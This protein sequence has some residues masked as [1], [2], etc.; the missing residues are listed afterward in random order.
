MIRLH[1]IDRASRAAYADALDQH[2]ALRLGI[3]E[4][5]CRRVLRAG[6]GGTACDPFDT[7]ATRYLLA[8]DGAGRVAGGTRLLPAERPTPLS[9]VFSHLADLRGFERSPGTWECT[10]FLLSPRFRE[11]RPLSRAAGVVAAGLIE[12]CLE[13]GIPRLNLVSETYWIPRMAELGWRPRPLG[14]PVAYAGASLCAVTI[15]MTE[16][17]L[18][19]TRAA[20]GI[21]TSVLARPRPAPPPDR[22]RAPGGRG[23][24][25]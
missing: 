20:Y 24:A 21:A 15:A 22:A 16:S 8:L 10:R 19:G 23:L 25:A 7:E 18:S 14:L 1:V 3:V 6:D 17:A 2:R 4:E 5:T 9:E 13:Q 12:H 11:D